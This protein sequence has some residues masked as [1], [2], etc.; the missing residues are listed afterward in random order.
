MH[1]KKDEG[2]KDSP[3]IIGSSK[4][5]AESYFH[6]LIRGCGGR[7]SFLLE[8][9]NIKIGEERIFEQKIFVFAF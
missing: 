3:L 9:K 5:S 7:V 1:A 8:L 6:H 2:I 4:L